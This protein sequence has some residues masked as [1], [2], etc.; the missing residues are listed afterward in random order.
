MGNSLLQISGYS[1]NYVFNCIIPVAQ[2][3]ALWAQRRKPS[4][5]TAYTSASTGE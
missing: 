4:T 1:L 5:S 3:D 2:G